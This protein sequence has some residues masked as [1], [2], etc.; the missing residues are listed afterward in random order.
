MQEFCEFLKIAIIKFLIIKK[1]IYKDLIWIGTGIDISFSLVLTVKLEFPFQIL[2]MNLNFQNQF[3]I[4]NLK[5]QFYIPIQFQSNITWKRECKS[6]HPLVSCWLS[7]CSH[8]DIQPETENFSI[9][10]NKY[11]TVFK[12]LFI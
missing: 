12:F 3:V 6:K 1:N 10:I 2:I 9:P 11:I 7:S 8:H 4:S 5:I